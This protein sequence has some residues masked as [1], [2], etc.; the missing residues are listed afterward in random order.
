[1]TEGE[2]REWI[3]SMHRVWADTIEE[4][5]M[6]FDY[7]D[8]LGFSTESIRQHWRAH[9]DRTMDFSV[10]LSYTG[11]GQITTFSNNPLQT[12]ISAADFLETESA[13]SYTPP[14]DT[15]FKSALE[16]LFHD[17]IAR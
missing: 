9:P 5:D 10:G 7:L 14:T 6:V 13:A 16:A 11:S 8:D 4:R 12:T 3:N 15:E 1:M 17:S 2:K